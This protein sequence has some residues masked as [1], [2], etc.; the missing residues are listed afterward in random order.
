MEEIMIYHLKIRVHKN[1]QSLEIHTKRKSNKTLPSKK[2]PKITFQ[3]EK[4]QSARLKGD[5]RTHAFKNKM[6]CDKKQIQERI[7]RLKKGT[8][9]PSY[10][11]QSRTRSSAKTKNN[12]YFTSTAYHSLKFFPNYL[13]QYD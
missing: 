7:K 9:E 3:K 8:R 2:Q 11:Q 12:L 6:Q 5:F 4:Y 1:K 13:V 10:H